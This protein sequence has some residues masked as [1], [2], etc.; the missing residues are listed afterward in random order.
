MRDRNH[1]FERVDRVID[2]IGSHPDARL[3]LARLARLACFSPYHFHRIFQAITGE[4]LNGHVRRVRLERAALLL[5][6]SPRKRITDVAL[7]VGFAGVAEFSR[8]FKNH[9]GLNATAWDRLAPLE[10]S[11]IG[12]APGTLPNYTREELQQWKT[13]ANI[14]VRVHT[15]QP[16]AY[17]YIRTYNPYGNTRLM[18]V[19]H[20]LMAWLRQR[21]TSPA[22][23]TII[24]MSMDDPT[25]T[26]AEKCRYDLGAAFPPAQAPARRECTAHSLSLR[27]LESGPLA[28][29][30][31]V[32][33]IGQVAR[34]W[35][36]LYKVWLPA[37]RYE[38]AHQ[39]AMEMFVKLPE[40]IGW[41]TFDLLAC[42]PVVLP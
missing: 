6:S 37:S 25:I 15:Q 22:G 21:G 24:G 7:Q 5:R 1:H 32:G 42:L 10:N 2:Y 17:A 31:C 18:D 20:S 28:S 38:P 12:K 39:P 9:F 27:D 41:T 16:L 35:H 4:T 11:K 30:H 34:A 26:P 33:D 23:V 36:Y 19:Y 14:R 8:A 29:I 3:S 13:A 40:E